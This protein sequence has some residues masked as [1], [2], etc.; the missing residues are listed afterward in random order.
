MSFTKIILVLIVLLVM[1]G[2]SVAMECTEKAKIK[3]MI[4]NENGDSVLCFRQFKIHYN[5]VF[6]GRPDL[7]RECH[8]G[9]CLIPRTRQIIYPPYMIIPLEGD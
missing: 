7:D 9:I 5:G 2:T 3:L 1:L 8:N 6:S 4:S